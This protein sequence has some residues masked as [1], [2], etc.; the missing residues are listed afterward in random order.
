MS[1]ECTAIAS[2]G[3]GPLLP[4][5]RLAAATDDPD[6]WSSGSSPPH[7]TPNIVLLLSSLNQS[8]SHALQTF[9]DI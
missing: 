8:G 9:L 4:S 1:Q 6:R 5:C 2:P 3:Q 7:L